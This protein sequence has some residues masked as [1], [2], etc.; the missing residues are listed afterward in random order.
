MSFHKHAHEHTHDIRT[1]FILNLVFALFEVV[2]GLYTNSVTILSDALHD[3]GDSLSL[4]IAWYLDHYA[5][6]ESS[7]RYSYGYRRF[8]LLGALITGVILLVGSGM[9]LSEAIPRL[10]NPESSDA[11]GMLAFAIAGIAINGFAALRLR[12][13]EGLNVRMVTWHLLEDVLGWVAVL[14]VSVILLF[15]EI[16]ILDPVLSILITVYVAYNVLRNLQKTLRLFLQST[17][18]EVEA[19]SFDEELLSLPG[20]ESVHHTHIWSL[21]GEQHVLTTHVVVDV[22]LTRDEVL[23]IKEAVRDRA[24]RL[25]VVHVTVEIEY[26]GEIC[27]LNKPQTSS[28]H[29]HAAHPGE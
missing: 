29:S 23:A 7:Q 9:V 13:G 10:I 1:A 17:P 21:D 22:C 26:S 20:V 24:M 25:G 14:I 16:N 8:S 11:Q 12:G 6:R 4:G 2:G 18:E 15:T 19:G 28:P 5:R 3:L 27:P